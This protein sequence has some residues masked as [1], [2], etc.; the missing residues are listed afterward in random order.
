L[1][2]QLQ[3]SQAAES[4]LRKE[5]A[6][7]AD[8]LVEIKVSVAKEL[9]EAATKLDVAHDRIEQLVHRNEG[10]QRIVGQLACDLDGEV[11][12]GCYADITMSEDA[13]SM[14][15]LSMSRNTSASSQ[16]SAL[17]FEDGWWVSTPA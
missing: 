15:T 9:Q 12:P 14:H 16:S 4:A 11:F 17:S 5:M 1:F 13:S 10:L 3:Q 7:L 8:G 2:K 6:D